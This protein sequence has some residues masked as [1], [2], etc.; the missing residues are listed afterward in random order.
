MGQMEESNRKRIRN[1]QLKALVL[2]TVAIAGGLAIALIA[3]NVLGAMAKLG[4]LPK[5]RQGEYIGTARRRLVKDGCLIEKD[6]FLRLTPRG[7]KQLLSLSATIARPPI[8][9]RWDEKWRVLIFDIPERRRAVRD[10]IRGM[11]LSS[12]FIRLQ[13]SVWV[14]PYPCEEFVAL[15]KADVGVGKDMLYLIVDSLENDLH[16]KKAFKL[17]PRHSNPNPPP[18]PKPIEMA[19]DVI[20]PRHDKITRS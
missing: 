20:L 7:E 19:L 8:L 2:G 6:G 5:G 10:K 9:K 17:P 15:L 12:G 16:I 3:P 18:L 11:L 14:F 4:L 13:D 1:R